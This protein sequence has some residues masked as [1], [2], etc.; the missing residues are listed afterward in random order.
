LKHQ[1]SFCCFNDDIQGTACVALAGIL[2]ALRAKNEGI[3]QQRF[4]FLG[5]G[6]AGV[7]IGE[8]LSMAIAKDSGKS[9]KEARKHC[10]FMDSKV[11]APVRTVLVFVI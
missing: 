4:L 10:F 5:A 9:L 8:I 3:D 7:G 1:T 11:T 2:S 6:E